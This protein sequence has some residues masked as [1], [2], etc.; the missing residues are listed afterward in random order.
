MNIM[1][2]SRSASPILHFAFALLQFLFIRSTSAQETVASDSLVAQE[3]A[4]LRAAADAVA[5]SVV[6]IR[7]I[8]GLDSVDGTFLANGPT[9]GLVI[10]ADGYILSSAFNFVQ[11]PASIL[12]LLSTG[13]QLPAELVAT[14]HSRMLVLLKVSGAS[15][16]VIPQMT[17]LD[18]IRVGTWAVAVGRTF[19]AERTNLAVGIVSAVN[20]MHG[21]AI[22]TDAAISTANYGGPLVDIRGRVLGVLVPMAPQATSEVA[23]VEW[24]DSGIGFAVPLASIASAIERMKK[25]EDQYPGLLGVSLAGRRPLTSPAE[26]AAVRPDSPAG[27]AGL[28]KGDRLIEVNGRPITSQ[29]ELR[30]C[31]GARYAGEEVK[32]VAT[33]GDERLERSIKLVGKMSAFRHAFVGIL[34][35]RSAAAAAESENDDGDHADGDGKESDDAESTKANAASNGIVVRAIYPGSPAAEA[36]IQPGDRI[37][38]I[39]VAKINSINEAIAELNNVIPGDAVTLTLTRGEQE[40]VAKLATTRLPTIA[41][42][43]LSSAYDDQAEGDGPAAAGETRDVKLAAM[44]Q[45]CKVYVPA[46]HATGRPHGMLLWLHAPG[47]AD[48]DAVIKQWQP[49][50]DR[51]G[52]ILVV[53]TAQD[54]NQWERTELD[55]L[56]RLML[57]LV[58]QYRPD[59]RR[60]VVYGQAG[61]GGLAYLAALPNR[62]VFAGVA[63]SAAPSRDRRASPTVSPHHALPS[64]PPFRQTRRNRSN[65]SR[66]S[67]SFRTPATPSRR[68]H[69]RPGR[70]T[71]AQRLR[72]PRPLD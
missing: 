34:P 52:L 65:I 39:N 4:A 32:V 23:G 10:S 40:I 57:R 36:R 48:P 72:R 21:K 9:T 2:Y 20:R 69:Q 26:L 60:V 33:R 28:K 17:P 50:C 61:G 30:L 3:E 49:I 62:N 31:A 56:G 47:D 58:R 18:E 64:M 6:Q 66:A 46:A 63:A 29:A 68:Q 41:P 53:P 59:P 11:K 51:D 67:R 43:D 45:D 13:Q 37:T 16:L 24:Y 19:R 14:D 22:Q 8:G 54:K 12:V 55:Y 7:T 5:P 44:P 71:L 1:G 35:M 42:A 25:G 70:K 38:R 27:R 15:K